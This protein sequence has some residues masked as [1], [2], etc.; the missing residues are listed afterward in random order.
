LIRNCTLDR[1]EVEE[2][3]LLGYLDCLNTHLQTANAA[4]QDTVAIL[5]GYYIELCNLRGE[6]EINGENEYATE[7]INKLKGLWTQTARGL[8]EL[9]ELNYLALQCSHTTFYEVLLNEYKNRIVALQGNLDG[10][11]TYKRKWLAK[12]LEVFRRLFPPGSV[13]IKQCEDNILDYDSKEL[14]VETDKYLEFLRENNEKPTK[15]FCK[16]GKNVNTVDDIEQILDSDGIAFVNAEEREK[17][18]TGFY[19]K[20][21]SKKIDRLIEIENLFTPEELNRIDARGQKIPEN[22]KEGLEGEISEIEL[23]TSL[24]NSNMSSC[25]GWDGVSYK[26]LRKVWEFIKTPIKKWQ[27]KGLSR[28]CSRRHCVQGLLN[29]FRKA[30]I[31]LGW[32]IG[33]QLHC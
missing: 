20:L 8:G 4:I 19:S 16:L 2:I 33:A 1:D 13:Q 26:L 23:E 27:M 12:K 29:L 15:G 25:P 30:K 22:I 18:I 7:Q 14:E 10:R 9:D 32:R 11:K 5:Q 6:I 21:Y 3:S 17:H 24:K 31:V 28:G